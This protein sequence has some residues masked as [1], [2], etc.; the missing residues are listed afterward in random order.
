MSLRQRIPFRFAENEEAEDDRVLDEQEQEE[1]IDR[2]RSQD[3]TANQ[4]Y[5]QLLRVPL[6][7]SCALHIIFLFKDPKESPLYAL[8]PAQ[9]PIPSIP[10]SPLF[11]LLNVLLQLNLVLHTFPPQHPLFL[12]ISRLEPPF[13]L[14][15]PFSHPVALVTPAVAPTLSLLLRRS[16]LDFA[17]WCMA[18]VMTMLVY[19]VQ[20]WIRSSDEQ[21]R[22]LEGMRYRAPGA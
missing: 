1:L 12:Y 10:R 6:A 17:W 22:E 9:T 8:F 20:V 13:S 4:L 2:L 16:W 5:L 19:T 18:L 7:L 11:A 14:P 21:I 15:L 3:A